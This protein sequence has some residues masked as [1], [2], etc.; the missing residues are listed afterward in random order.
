MTS[1]SSDV[2]LHSCLPATPPARPSQGMLK[3]VRWHYIT[4]LKPVVYKAIY[5]TCCLAMHV[6]D[7]FM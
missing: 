3:Q 5:T 6:S 4:V 2:G 1:R 7:S